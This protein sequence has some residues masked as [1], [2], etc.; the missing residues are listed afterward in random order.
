MAWLVVTKSRRNKGKQQGKGIPTNG[1][2]ENQYKDAQD[3]DGSN[4]TSRVL[5]EVSAVLATKYKENSDSLLQVKPFNNPLFKGKGS[6]SAGGLV[7]QPKD[8]VFLPG[9]DSSKGKSTSDL[10]IFQSKPS[11]NPNTSSTR[12]KRLR[13]E[14]KLKEDPPNPDPLLMNATVSRIHQQQKEKI[15]SFPAQGIKTA[16]DVEVI[17][18][19]R[20]RFKDD[21]VP[22]AASSDNPL[23]V[24]KDE[25]LE[26]EDMNEESDASP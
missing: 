8:S 15:Y 10:V 7:N 22:E 20:L 13:I 16:M 14:S 12:K 26:N 5:Q 2:K 17:S 9:K 6:S 4:K 23:K 24:Q 1:K 11:L 25:A 18:E 19:N 21:E 3:K